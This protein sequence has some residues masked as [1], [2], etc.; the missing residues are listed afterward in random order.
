MMEKKNVHLIE[1][2]QEI[3]NWI[4]YYAGCKNISIQ[5]TL[6][7]IIVSGRHALGRQE[8]EMANIKKGDPELPPRVMIGVQASVESLSILRKIYLPE[9]Y[10]Q[11]LLAKE[12]KELID[13]T[14][15]QYISEKANTS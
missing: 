12:V 10:D 2:E 8:T 9:I 6:N 7:R 13:R 11:K 3:Q 1:V 4:E 14:I 15:K 5:D